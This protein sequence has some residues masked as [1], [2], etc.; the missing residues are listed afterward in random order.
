MM[1]HLAI[2]NFPR[3]RHR[4]AHIEAPFIRIITVEQDKEWE[5]LNFIYPGFEFSFS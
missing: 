3:F 2:Y 5:E 1:N 4:Y